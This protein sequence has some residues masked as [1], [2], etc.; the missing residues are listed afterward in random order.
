MLSKIFL[1]KWIFMACR[2]LRMMHLVP[3]PLFLKVVCVIGTYPG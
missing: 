1:A 2:F 3:H